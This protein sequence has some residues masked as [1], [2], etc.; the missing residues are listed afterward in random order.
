MAHVNAFDATDSS[1]VWEG[2]THARNHLLDQTWWTETS[3]V[4]TDIRKGGMGG[5][6]RGEAPAWGREEPSSA[7]FRLCGRG[8]S[9]S[10][11]QPVHFALRGFVEP[12]KTTTTS[13][14]GSTSSD[15]EDSGGDSIDGLLQITLIT[16]YSG[17]YS[18]VVHYEGNRTVQQ[19]CYTHHSVRDV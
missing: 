2:F 19:A 12:G 3:I 7:I 11:G 4:F 18:D 13:G 1:G 5:L 6:A 16:R 9:W 8:I 17:E 14:G 10:Q 15:G